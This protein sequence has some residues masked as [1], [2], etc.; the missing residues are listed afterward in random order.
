MGFFN[1]LKFWKKKKGKTSRISE[2]EAEGTADGIIMPRRIT[3][4]V[5]RLLLH[6]EVR[7]TFD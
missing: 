3:G 2:L 7:S 4:E 1:K 6:H 5:H